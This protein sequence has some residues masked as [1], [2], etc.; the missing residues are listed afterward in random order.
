MTVKDIEL[1]IASFELTEKELERSKIVN[2]K[3]KGNAFQV[4]FCG[5]FS[6]GK[7]TI[8]NYL[9]GA[10]ML[11][12]SP[13]PTSA[14]IIGI[15]NGKLGLTVHTT[16]G[17]ERNWEGEIPWERVREWGMNG[18]EI[19]SITIQA[20]LPFLGE[21]SI[22][23]D[24]PGVDST[25]PTHQAVTLEALYTTDFIVYVTDYNHVQS[26]TNLTFL[27]QLSD[28][29][30][31]IYL[32]INQIDKH[33]EQELSFTS[34][35]QSIRHTFSDWGI[36]IL[37]LCYTSMKTRNHH[38]SD[39]HEVEKDLKAMLYSGK[40]LLPYAKQR[41]QQGYYL[42]IVHRLQEDKEDEL[43]AIKE[44]MKETGYDI[45]QLT[46][47]EAL[48]LSYE[49]SLRAKETFEEEMKVEIQRLTKDVTIFPYTTTELTRSWLESIQPNFKVGLFFAKKKTE[50]EQTRRLLKLVEEVHDKVKSQLEFHFHRLFQNYDFTLLTNREQVEQELETLHFTPTGSFFTDAVQ[51][52]PKNS[53]YIY[54]FTKDRTAAIIRELRQKAASITSLICKG[55]E[56]YW[57]KEQARLKAELAELKE[58]DIFVDEMKK[59]ELA[60]DEM[61]TI[62]KERAGQFQDAGGYERVLVQSMVKN[63]PDF[64]R[65]EALATISLPKESVIETDWN[66][67]KKKIVEQFDEEGAKV[68]VDKLKEKL[69]PYLDDERMNVERQSLLDRAN[70][71]QQQTFTISLFGA[72][73]AGKSSF[74][75]ALLGDQ[76]L[77]VSPHPTTATV[78]TVKQSEPGHRTRTAVVQ[79]KT[80]DQLDAEIRSVAEELDLKLSLETIQSFK[81]DLKA[82]ATSW[83]KTYQSYLLTLKNS[84]KENEQR[85]GTQ[86]EVELEDLGPYVANEHDACLIDQ[87]TLYYDCPLTKSGIVLVDTPG[88]NSIHGRHTNVAFKQ[89]RDSDAIFYLSYYNHAFSKAD[90]LFLQQMAKVNG[91][92]RTDKLYF[93]L[94][95][96]D[97]ASSESELNGVRKHVY[98][99]LV[100]CGI[101]EPRLYPLSSKKGLLG[102]QTGEDRDRLF[103][104]F[105]R[106]FYE[107][108]IAELKR[109]SY[110]LLQDALKHY[111][112]TLAEGARY[113]T[114]EE[115]KKQE[116]RNKLVQDVDIWKEHV[117]TLKP[118]SAYQR[119]S[120]EVNQLYLYLR[121][122]VRFV[123]GDQFGDSVNVT[124]VTGNS[125][126][127]QQQAL[128]LALKEWGSEGEHFLKQE[129]QAT[130]V[131]I[132]IA[133]YDATEKWFTETI[134]AI[135]V[136]FP[137]FTCSFEQPKHELKI[138][139]ANRFLPIPFEE[140]MSSFQSLKLFFEQQQVRKLKDDLVDKGTEFASSA[141][142]QL[143]EQT[144]VQLEHNFTETIKQA[145]HVFIHALDREIDRFDVL[146]DPKHFKTLKEEHSVIRSLLH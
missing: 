39:L 75:N 62:Y 125:K 40:E 101:D 109:L 86:F 47:R 55:M 105:E 136:D 44:K 23:Y 64:E 131:R 12:T 116:R 76:V 77:P 15:K 58:L 7:S 28:E 137:S 29:K 20:P 43:D 106:D 82:E 144:L 25:D 31:P 4:A 67:N 83:Q 41:L 115:K 32:I 11:P 127:A 102:K 37:K 72:F 111:E 140:Y 130:F 18:G 14:N 30:K 142:R 35:D 8:L 141:L 46:K 61:I 117:E 114:G 22:I 9:L 19:S 17:D 16:D 99:Q 26:E 2:E 107:Q 68:W 93:I 34:F 52:G 126:R 145:K 95:A 134:K 36:H 87:V 24:T 10:D 45:D 42:S 63:I 71:F 3:K 74:A 110:T 5:H 135:R 128:L 85:L 78:N 88:V 98:D 81:P 112:E 121:E 84:L 66:A 6:A 108:T 92:F 104:N 33:D 50:E 53:E 124:T 51:A 143:E 146:T 38:L 97:L 54:T 73:S 122:R 119:A 94:N 1:E 129:I 56:K 27:K 138:E 90:Q 80:R 103:T 133:L 79:V 118:S 21:E 13:I 48:S 49:R 96:A 57:Q 60:F 123:L 65:S 91:G 132:E 113:A 69:A 100:Q 89:V 139:T 59:V 70:K 120:G